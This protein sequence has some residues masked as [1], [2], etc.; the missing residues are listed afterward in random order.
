[1]SRPEAEGGA[2]PVNEEQAAKETAPK[3]KKQ[4]QQPQQPADGGEAPQKSKAE[5]RRERA[6]MQEAQRAAKAL[7]KDQIAQERAAG[8]VPSA[9]PKKEQ[10]K[11]AAKPPA[12]EKPK[13]PKAPKKTKKKEDYSSIHPAVLKLGEQYSNFEIVGGNARCISM[14]QGLKAMLKDYTLEKEKMRFAEEFPAKLKKHI[15]YLT[16]RRKMSFSMG[17]AVNSLKSRVA[18]L[19]PDATLE[20][21]K[22]QIAKYIDDYIERILLASKTIAEVSVGLTQA[23][24]QI[25]DG[26]VILTYAKSVAIEWVFR[27]AYSRGVKFEVI[28]VDSRPLHEGRKLSLVLS[29]LGIPT[30][31]CLIN[32]LSTLLPRCNKVFVGASTLLTNGSLVSRAGTAM[33]AMMAKHFSLPVLC[34]CETYKFADKV[35]LGSLTNNEEADPAELLTLINGKESPLVGADGSAKVASYMYDLT[36]AENIDMVVTELGPMHP[37]SVPVIV[38]DKTYE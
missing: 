35:W 26:D 17:N 23:K 8:K 12:P 6:A 18:A 33:V 29:S 25:K 21:A 34:Y 13:E 5:L 30:T 16:G 20:V 4:Q 28:C 38:R 36:P 11:K 10:P 15:G 14:L 24:H 2:T 31:Y 32:S 3:E 9:E 7:K 27:L 1:M 19:P 37:T 22:G